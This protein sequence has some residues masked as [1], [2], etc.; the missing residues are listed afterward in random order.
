MCW[1]V[2]CDN[3]EYLARSSVIAVEEP[4]TE[5]NEVKDQMMMFTKNLETKIGI[6]SI[7]IFEPRNPEN[8]YYSP[9]DTVVDDDSYD[10]PYGD[11][12][13]DLNT[14][15]VDSRYLNELDN[16]I[17]AQASLPSKDGLPWLVIFKKRNLN[18]R[19]VSVG[20]LNSNTIL[21]S[22]IHELEFP[23]RRIEEYSAN[24]VLENMLDQ[25]GKND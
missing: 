11:D 20:S 1:F 6:S 25:V 18:H 9:F 15:E 12:F 13:I 24:V 4:S 21:D 22:S 14:N 3:G 16:L 8:I 10:L 23:D 7:P 2:I 19:E 17:G 5:S